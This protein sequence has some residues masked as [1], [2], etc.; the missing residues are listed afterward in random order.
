MSTQ[1]NIYIDER[2]FSVSHDGDP[3]SLVPWIREITKI[4]K[5]KSEKN[6]DM[7]FRGMLVWGFLNEEGIYQGGYGSPEWEY[8]I[9]EDGRI[10]SKYCEDDWKEETVDKVE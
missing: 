8:T 2:E 7:G 5:E 3:E 1:A 10:M 9:N 4:A 6:P